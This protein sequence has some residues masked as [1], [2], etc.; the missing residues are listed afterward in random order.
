MENFT[1][2]TVDDEIDFLETL[3]TMKSCSHRRQQRTGSP[4]I[5]KPYSLRYCCA[6]R[7]NGGN[8]RH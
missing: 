8:G 7:E 4:G 2:L 5:F 1:V 6:G 3:T